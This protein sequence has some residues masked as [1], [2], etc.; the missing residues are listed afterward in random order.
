L[1]R[2]RRLLVAAAAG[3]F[4]LALSGTAFAAYNP[5]LLV[6][7]TNHA[8]GRGAPVVI[9]VG[10]D[11]NDD[12]TAM[13][14][15]YSPPGYRVNLAQPPGTTLGS[16]SG[17]VKVASLGGSRVNVEGTVK[18]DNPANH[19]SNQCSPGPHEAVWLLEFTVSGN[20][21]RVPMYVDRVTTAPESAFASARMRTCLPSPYV[22]P[23]QGAP[24]G[25]S[26]V[27]AAFS[28]R[29]VFTNPST[30]GGYAWNGVFVPY[31]PGTATPNAANSA[32]SSSFLRLPVRVTMTAKR[33]RRGKRTFALVSACV[34]EAGQGV[35]GIRI[36][37]HGASTAR[38]ANSSRA[39]RVA[40]GTTNARGCVRTRVRVR[41][42]SMFLRASSA[43][44]ARQ[45]PGCQPTIVPRCSQPSIA[46]A[47]DLSSGRAKRVRR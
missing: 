6:A 47:F 34:S 8:L 39:R 44:P 33:Q 43:V 22:P 20:A 29:S 2:T 10:Q 37:I 15:I 17:V 24:A 21:F 4:A 26:I 32:Q 40:G 36:A 23:P 9:G 14:T 45:A 46:P 25:A 3:A 27:V 42:R 11:E 12:A 1:T 38:R 31:T 41:T 16:L 5:S 7:G 35:R 18:T 13:G 30:R 28:V 19:V